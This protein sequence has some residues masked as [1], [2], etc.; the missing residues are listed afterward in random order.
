MY[1]ELTVTDLHMRR[2]AR[3]G[4]TGYG[5]FY[6]ACVAS[7]VSCVGPENKIFHTICGEAPTNSKPLPLKNKSPGLCLCETSPEQLASVSVKLTHSAACESLCVLC[8]HVC[9]EPF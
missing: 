1:S 7:A 6:G 5:F 8:A 9:I 3:T 4:S 2:G